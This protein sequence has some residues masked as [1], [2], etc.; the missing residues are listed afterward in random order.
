MRPKDLKS[1]FSWDARCPSII[2]NVLFVPDHYTEHQN[3]KLPDWKELFENNNPIHIEYCSG[4]GEWVISQA[5]QNPHINWIAVEKQF[6]RVRKIWSKSQN[7]QVNNLFI[8]CGEA[9]TFT[10]NYI[11]RPTFSAFHVNFPDPWPKTRHAKHR[12][13]QQPFADEIA[14]CALPGAT[15]TF[16]TDDK[17]YATQMLQV[18]TDH[19]I[20]QNPTHTILKE[21]SGESYFDRLWRSK[22]RQIHQINSINC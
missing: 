6:P 21:G 9:L 2:G 14:R 18:I 16:V 19:S 12:I 8:I 10:Q 22:G 17:P 7:R 4:N 11:K 13:I 5:K 1:P 3:F 20:W 15:A